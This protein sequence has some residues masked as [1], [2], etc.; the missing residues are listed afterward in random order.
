MPNPMSAS[1]ASG[2]DRRTI[3][4]NLYQTAGA[5][6]AALRCELNSRLGRFD[7]T[8]ELIRKTGLSD[9]QVI[10]DIG[11]GSGHHLQAY[12]GIVGE[13][14]R[15]LGF[16][17]PEAAVM[18]TRHLGLEASVAS[19]DAIPLVDSSLDALTCNYA[20]YYMPDLGQALAE[21]A[22]LLKPGG[23]LV[24]TGPS[25]DSNEEIYRF[26]LAATGRQPSD[27]DRMALGYVGNPVVA[28]LPAAGFRLEDLESVS[29]PVVFPDNAQFLEYWR[30]T[31]LFI[32]TVAVW[33]AAEALATGRQL[34]E[35]RQRGFTVTKRIT[36]LTARRTG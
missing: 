28:A 35:Q 3:A 22:R 12:A 31:S 30:S 8:A 21:W 34:L 19:G 29:N 16:D 24:I 27:A 4:E 10:A 32:R 36:F 26:H 23:M 33:R 25:V 18:A 9:G 20:V 17:F 7:L 5:A 14:G 1:A 15:A 6:D 13:R 2:D 11:C